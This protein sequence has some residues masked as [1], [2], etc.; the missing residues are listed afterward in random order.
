MER[1][2]LTHPVFSTEATRRADRAAIEEFGLP[3]HTLME[4]A[5]RAAATEL[6][7]RLDL[8]RGARALVLAGH[9]NNGG[10]GLAMARILAGRGLAVTVVTTA[11]D[12]AATPET[13]RN[14]A[15]LRTM[16]REGGCDLRVLGAD[17]DA[18]PLA[19]EADVTVDALLGIGV[20][21][22]LREPIRGL[23]LAC[24]EAR[25]VV[26]VDVPT[27]IDSD[28]G[29]RTDDAAVRADLTVTMAAPKP[30]LLFGAGREHAGEVVVADIGLP[31][32][33][34][35][36]ALG[37][38]GS[39]RIAT[40]ALVS[41]LLPRRA[42]DAHKNS[43]G[44]VLVL[45]GSDAFTGAAALASVAAGRAGA[46]YVTCASTPAV[47]AAIDAQSPGT[48]TVAVATTAGGGV[49]EEAAEEVVSR[50]A[51]A[52]ALLVGPG[53]GQ[54]PSTV[55]LV[56][57]VLE[58]VTLPVVLDADGLNALARLD[59][60]RFDP[61]QRARWVLTPHLG[62]FRRLV[63]ACGA[64]LD[65]GDLDRRTWLVPR[66]AE[67]L[68]GTLL[69]KGAP[70]VTACTDGTVWVAS[71]V[72]PGLAVAG[73]GDVLAGTIAGL[74]AQGLGTAEATV[75]AQHVGNAV[76]AWWSETRAGVALRPTDMTEAL[77]QVLRERFGA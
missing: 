76:A 23:A 17:A 72:Q 64:A 5:S 57:Q 11:A 48:A 39:A 61:A 60:T 22:A 62:E 30:G 36:G 29:T 54:D 24:A 2:E 46:G 16:E 59:P 35:R 13:A 68:G 37:Q 10:D 67:R 44:R 50:A 42:V 7:R 27:G 4:T 47:Q 41:G 51:R 12:G 21:G 66:W 69:L 8:E 28:L 52:D 55:A 65:E 25:R 1:L 70:T 63:A 9:G 33:L 14:L 43:A 31:P 32:H 38:P 19:R 45:A 58:R 15:L 75:C 40:D 71:E 73:A 6:L 18:A 77:P 56:G 20:T 3:S 34:A 74:I 49:A 53:L 26:A